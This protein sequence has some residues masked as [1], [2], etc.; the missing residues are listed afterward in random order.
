MASKE[1]S[2]PE[3]A[4]DRGP[5]PANADASTARLVPLDTAAL[6]PLRSWLDERLDP[7]LSLDRRQLFLVAVTEAV[8]N[9]MEAHQRAGVGHPIEVLVSADARLVTVEDHGG[10]LDRDLTGEPEV[11]APAALRG[12]GLLIIRRICP[13]ARFERT[14]SGSRVELPFPI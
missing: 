4:L 10:G 13:D 7:G 1:P 2:S 14:D 11:P 6:A 12:R 9:A 8:T 3:P 5:H